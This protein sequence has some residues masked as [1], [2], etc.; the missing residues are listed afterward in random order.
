MTNWNEKSRH[1]VKLN[2]RRNDIHFRNNKYNDLEEY[3]M[4]K[5]KS[6]DLFLPN[7][8]QIFARKRPFFYFWGV[9]PRPPIPCVYEWNLHCSWKLLFSYVKSNG[10]IPH[11][12]TNQ[13]WVSLHGWW[14]VYIKDL[15]NFF[16]P[17]IAN[18]G[19][20]EKPQS[21]WFEMW[22]RLLVSILWKFGL[23]YVIPKTF[24]MLQ[25]FYSKNSYSIKYRKHRYLWIWKK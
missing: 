3:A 10:L 17:F 15:L 24:F 8:R 5:Y 19:V 16:N 11:L 9:D 14:L 4:C 6:G 21:Y 23:I 7:L 1:D 13:I 25:N 12:R 18:I 2:R 20:I 22:I